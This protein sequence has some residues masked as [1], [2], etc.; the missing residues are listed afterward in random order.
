MFRFRLGMILTLVCLAATGCALIKVKKEHKRT[1]ESTAIVGNVL[2]EFNDKG[3]IIVAACTTD[4]KRTIVH[5]TV[6]H[7]AGEYELTVVHGSYFVFAFQD[8]NSNLIYDAGEPAGQHGDPKS[9]RAPEVGV[10]FDVNIEIPKGGS[11][12]AI[13]HGTEIAAVKPEKLYSRQAG[14]IVDLADERFC[15]ENGIKGFWEPGSFFNELGGNIYFLEAYDPNKIPI[16]F[17]HGATGT[18]SGWQ[19]FV[20]HIDRTRYQPWFYYYPTGVRINSMAYL[21]LWKLTNLQ[22]RYQFKQMY[23]VAH[24]MG[25]LVARSFLV[26]YGRQFPYVELFISLATPWGGDHMAELGVRQSP[27]VIPSWIDMQPEGDFV[28]SLYQKKLPETVSFY[29]FSGHRGSR[30]PFRSNN[31][32]TIT[33]ASIMDYRSQSEAKMNYVFNEDHASIITSKEVVAQL[34]KILDEFHEKQ[35][36]QHQRS[37]GFVKV[38]FEY[39]YPFKGVR[40]ETIFM[41]GPSGKKKAEVITYLRESD[42]NKILGPFPPGGYI[43]AM[44][45][46]AARP[47]KK[48]IFFSIEN[49]KTKEL[50]FVF[51]PDGELYGCV[52]AALKT[53]DKFVGRPDYTYQ[54]EDEA[55][56]IE[57]ILLTGNGI[58]RTLKSMA[59]TPRDDLFLI[60]RKDYCTG[61]CF[62]FF[63]LPAGDYK[64]FIQTRGYQP[65]EKD[66]SVIPGVPIR[67]RV[68]ELTPE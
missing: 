42:N 62:G 10:V 7:G 57:S 14:A 28:K 51:E 44:V 36:A 58:E 55:I 20:D 27:A 39:T 38:H 59:P 46:M 33:L 6:L 43:A 18:P 67:F 64:L 15:E 12:I 9:V 26:N 63:G 1:L 61:K 2:G 48:Y 23:I 54:S 52:T 16:L 56:N 34:N 60:E 29:M 37:G 3:P 32:G 5:Y 25:G 53:E 4:K 50:N 19:Y 24:S 68:T 41:I 13:P 8:Q 21:L 47:H 40:P 45:A 66:Y 22:T 11:K 49:N 17:I 30:N 65:V 31:D 35:S